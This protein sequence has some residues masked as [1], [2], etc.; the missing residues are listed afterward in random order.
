MFA[1]WAAAVLRLL[2][3]LSLQEEGEIEMAVIYL[4]KLLRGRVVQN[5][6][7]RSDHWA[8]ISP[9]RGNNGNCV[10][11][12][13]LGTFPAAPCSP[14]PMYYRINYPPPSAILVHRATQGHAKRPCLPAVGHSRN[15]ACTDWGLL[16]PQTC[17]SAS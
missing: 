7:R 14:V 5:M 16:T 3:S 11:A 2:P 1:A 15:S 12:C 13:C 8:R 10:C 6:V 17:P 9:W 4:Q